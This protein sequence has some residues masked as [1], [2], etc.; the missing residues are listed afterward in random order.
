MAEDESIKWVPENLPEESYKV[1]SRGLRYHSISFKQLGFRGGEGQK[2]KFLEFMID[3]FKSEEDFVGV[4]NAYTYSSDLREALKSYSLQLEKEP[5]NYE[6]WIGSAVSK[7]GLGYSTTDIVNDY[8]QA[9]Q[10]SE[11]EHIAQNID[12][13]ILKLKQ[14]TRDY[15]I[16]DP[17]A[18]PKNIYGDYDC[19][20]DD[21]ETEVI[22]FD[23][24]EAYPIED[25]AS[26]P[27][28]KPVKKRIV[29]VPIKRNSRQMYT[30]ILGFLRKETNIPIAKNESG[31]NYDTLVELLRNHECR[32]GNLE[33]CGGEG[34]KRKFMEHFTLKCY[35]N[36]DFTGVGNAALFDRDYETAIKSFSRALELGSNPFEALI[37][38]AIAKE[39][40]GLEGITE[41]INT[42]IRCAPNPVFACRAKAYHDVH[43]EIVKH[44]HPGEQI[45]FDDA[46]KVLYDINRRKF[47]KQEFDY[48]KNDFSLLLLALEKRH[49]SWA[50]LS[51]LDPDSFKQFNTFASKQFVGM[52][53]YLLAGES[54]INLGNYEGALDIFDEGKEVQP[55]NPEIY[56]G[57]Y[58][59]ELYLGLDNE[60]MDDLEKARKLNLKLVSRL[61]SEFDRAKVPIRAD[62]EKKVVVK[63]KVK[64]VVHAVKDF[65]MP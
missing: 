13:L 56:F 42:A 5:D 41:D 62:P 50:D 51:G 63:R 29:S 12:R 1:L 59:A 31:E 21:D 17:D 49:L 2:K 52:K 36:K 30:N 20:V 60:A 44:K 47:H 64:K 3:Y 54:E 16:E 27:E 65:F 48:F 34:Q 14:Q 57:A 25:L 58:K 35:G 55:E 6:A 18:S 9:K 23:T 32:F 53:Q 45:E 22:S 8:N 40:L 24:L 26:D 11:N 7:Q 39:S 61:E 10:F 4:G 43:S 38:I 15:D 28:L 33:F 19:E 46:Q 37:G